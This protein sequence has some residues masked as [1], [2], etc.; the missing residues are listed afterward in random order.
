MPE[1]VQ[2]F[3]KV[4]GSHLFVALVTA[5]ITVSFALGSYKARIDE[6]LIKE[7]AVQMAFDHLSMDLNNLRVEVA[8]LSGEM[9]QDRQ[10]KR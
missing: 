3:F 9:R 4:A 2:Q 7:A 10:S 1:P 6:I 5:L 8:K